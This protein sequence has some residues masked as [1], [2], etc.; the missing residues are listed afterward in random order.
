MLMLQV[1]TAKCDFYYKYRPTWPQHLQSMRWSI[2]FKD[3]I[4]NRK[5]TN[6]T[7]NFLIHECLPENEQNFTEYQS[8]CLK[9]EYQTS[10][11]LL[12]LINQMYIQV[13]QSSNYDRLNFSC[14]LRS[15][16]HQ[17]IFQNLKARV[18]F[19][20]RKINMNSKKSNIRDKRKTGQSWRKMYKNLSDFLKNKHIQ[21]RLSHQRKV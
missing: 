5:K 3:K 18:R 13:I 20:Q 8:N 12:L 15:F 16:S 14:K 11:M 1:P 7:Q 4:T 21:V 10:E 9:T 2:F 6:E 17:R 19:F